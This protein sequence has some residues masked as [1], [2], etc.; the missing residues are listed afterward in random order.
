MQAL[1]KSIKIALLV[2]PTVITIFMALQVK[3]IFKLTNII[4]NPAE[5]QIVCFETNICAIEV[6]NTWYRISSVILMNETFPEEYKLNEL[7]AQDPIILL[8]PASPKQ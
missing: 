7:L 1:T 6:N 4:V 8:D 2:I 5:P 3:N